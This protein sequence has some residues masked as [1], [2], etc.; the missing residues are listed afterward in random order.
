MS[1][2]NRDFTVYTFWCWSKNN[3][4]FTFVF[5]EKK[6]LNAH[7][8]NFILAKSS[9][10]LLHSR[11]WESSK[12]SSLFIIPIGPVSRFRCTEIGRNSPG[13]SPS[14]RSR[15]RMNYFVRMPREIKPAS[16]RPGS[17][18]L[19]GGFPG[20]AASSKGSFLRNI[21]NVRARV[22]RKREALSLSLSLSLYLSPALF[23]NDSQFEF[24]ATSLK[25]IKRWIC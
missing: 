22:V 6:E 9:E 19:S 25:T 5:H 15:G 20:T 16:H 8:R 12:V 18:R 13:S 10:R 11:P 21:W 4:K 24:E 17:A 7:A 2:L 23:N 1:Q 14:P 3:W